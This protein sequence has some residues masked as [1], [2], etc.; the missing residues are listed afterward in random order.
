MKKGNLFVISGPSGSGKTTLSSH[1]LKNLNNLRFSVSFTT[2]PIR[3]GEVNGVDYFFVDKREFE[4]MIS[5]AQ[6]A[7]WAK[8]HG[9]LYGTPIDNI[10]DANEKGID[11]LLDID[12]QGAEQLKQRFPNAIFIFVVPP[13][14]EVLENR[15]K[16]RNSEKKDDISL[17]LNVVKYEIE[18]SKEYDYIIINDDMNTAGKIIESIIIFERNSKSKELNTDKI[19][20]LALIADGAR[21]NK[22]Y[23]EIIAKKF[24]LN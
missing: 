6:F 10:K 16:M 22:I 5:N 18:Q 8:V 13:S 12:V 14:M 21:S 24:N 17:R 2:R 15:L 23:D 1:A 19:K 7:E 9:N 3:N 4:N 11:I 20:K